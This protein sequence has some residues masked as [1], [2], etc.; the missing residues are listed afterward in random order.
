MTSIQQAV[1]DPKKLSRQR[2]RAYF[3]GVVCCVEALLLGYV[4]FF[5]VAHMEA[6]VKQ[7]GAALPVI[8][9]YVF[10]FRHYCAQLPLGLPISGGLIA[11]GIV[12][13]LLAK[14]LQPRLAQMLNVLVF[15][16]LTGGIVVIALSMYLPLRA[17]G[18]SI[19]SG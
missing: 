16:L 1:E 4:F 8:T 7:F 6:L 12:P 2:S 15:L 13:F 3:Y 5:W 9:V 14:S 18:Q 10:E 19:Q 17:M 11:L